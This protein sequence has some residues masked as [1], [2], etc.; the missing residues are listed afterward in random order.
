MNRNWLLA[1][2]FFFVIEITS[3]IMET[4][5]VS[6]KNNSLY[7]TISTAPFPRAKRQPSKEQRTNRLPF[8]R[9]PT[10]YE[11]TANILHYSAQFVKLKTVDKFILYYYNNNSE[12]TDRRLPSQKIVKRNLTAQFCKAGRLFLYDNK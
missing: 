12:V 3:A 2:H 7:V 9:N 1:V 5:R 11:C 10:G 6:N 8:Y 4:I